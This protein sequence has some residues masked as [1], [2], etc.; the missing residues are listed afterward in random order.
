MKSKILAEADDLIHGDRANDYGEA[1]E[2]FA[3]IATLWRVYLLRRGVIQIDSPN[4]LGPEDVCMM[5]ALLKVARLAGDADHKDS[6]VDAI[7]YLALR[8]KCNVGSD[9]P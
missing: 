2:S 7:G 3:A 8:E 1:R 5:M 6:L 9:R 4:V